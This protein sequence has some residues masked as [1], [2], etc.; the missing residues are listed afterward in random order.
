[1]FLKIQGVTGEASDKDHKGEID[2]V[3]WSWG[4]Q[5]PTAMDGKANAKAVMTELHVVKRVDQSSPTLM[6]YLRSYKVIPQAILT[7]RKAGQSPLE[8]FRIELT[9]ARL[10]SLQTESQSSELVERVALN[11]AKFK[12]CYTPQDAQGARGGGDNIFEADALAK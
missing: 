8:Y 4:M 11:F 12:A 10:T 2:V 3:S 7:V 6:N 5:A 9:N 1:M